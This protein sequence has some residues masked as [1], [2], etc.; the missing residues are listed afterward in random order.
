[1]EKEEAI[2]IQGVVTTALPNG[3]FKVKQIAVMRF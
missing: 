1:M 2:E 3:M